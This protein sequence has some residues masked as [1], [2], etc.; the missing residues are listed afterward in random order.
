MTWVYIEPPSVPGLPQRLLAQ[1]GTVIIATDGRYGLKSL[2][3]Q[4]GAEALVVK[5]RMTSIVLLSTPGKSFFM[6]QAGEPSV[7]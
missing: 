1:A 4:S 6:L 5:R 3:T 7:V 2:A